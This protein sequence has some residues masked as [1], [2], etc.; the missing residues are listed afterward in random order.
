ME[1]KLIRNIV[2]KGSEK[3]ANELVSRYYNQ[4]Y[5][6]VYRQ[7]LEQEQSLD[8]TQEIFISMLQGLHQ[9]DAKRSS[10]STWLYK[11]ATFKVIDYFRSRQFKSQALSDSMED[12]ELED[13]DDFIV[14]MLQKEEFAEVLGIVNTL[15]APEQ[16]ILRLKLFAE[17]TFREIAASLEISES[18]VKTK[19]YRGLAE[20]RKGVLDKNAK[21]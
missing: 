2:K 1:Q 3:A 15:K 17:N 21:G 18:T 14:S 20:V 4:I 10:F 12:F 16:E 5:R 11:I 8:L 7:V 6:Y 9:F 19:Y 13:S